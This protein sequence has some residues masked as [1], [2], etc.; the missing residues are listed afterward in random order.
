[1]FIGSYF[2][3]MLRM[4]LIANRLIDKVEEGVSFLIALMGRPRK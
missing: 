2:P 3:Q 4:P 1:M